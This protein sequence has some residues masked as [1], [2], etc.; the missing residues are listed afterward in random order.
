VEQPREENT[1]GFFKMFNQVNE[2]MKEDF[3]DLYQD[4]YLSC[5]QEKVF[6][7]FLEQCFGVKS[8]DQ[9]PQFLAAVESLFD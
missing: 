8:D 4:I 1:A 6:I 5:G 2:I 9:N 7:H 3:Y